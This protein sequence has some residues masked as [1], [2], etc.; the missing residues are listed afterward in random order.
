M[1]EEGHADVDAAVGLAEVGGAR[2]GVDVRGDLVDAGERVE[3]DGV[4]LEEG[5]GVAGDEVDAAGGGV[6]LRGSEALA[7]D[8]GLVD[9][10][11]VR[12]DGAEIRG[13]AVADAVAVEG[14]ADVGTH[15]GS[16]RGDEDEL[17]VAGEG[18]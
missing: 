6:L 5:E 7:L 2:V 4:G 1:V 8:T 11:Y 17:D 18:E 12:E 3:D 10:I 13:V 16:G 14:G 9:D 15:R